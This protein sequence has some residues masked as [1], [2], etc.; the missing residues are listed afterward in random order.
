MSFVAQAVDAYATTQPP[1]P[2]EPK[3]CGCGR[4]F[5]EAEWHRLPA[6]PGGD[7]MDNGDGGWICL[8]NCPCGSTLGKQTWGSR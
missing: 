4:S 5:D 3:H 2:E 8:R 7:R 6:P 1:P